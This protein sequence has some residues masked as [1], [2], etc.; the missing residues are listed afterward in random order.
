MP[1]SSSLDILKFRGKK[2]EPSYFFANKMGRIVFLALEEVAGRE[3]MRTILSAAR[4]KDRFDDYPPNDF[5]TDF[6]FG[7]LARIHQAMDKL[8]GPTTGRQLSRRVGRVCF[9]TGAE[10]LRPVLG[11]ADVLFRIL[12]LRTRVRIGFDVLAH[13][14]D[15]FSDQ[16][17]RLEEDQEYFRWV[18]ERCGVCW[19]RETDV[20]CCDLYVGLLEEGLRWFSGG[21]AFFIEESSCIAA[22]QDTCT[23]LVGK[24]PLTDDVPPE[25]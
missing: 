18:N 25:E 13:M 19:G 7:A 15:R 10:E 5:A 2:E 14:S 11:I 8:Y 3:S 16:V 17:V 24:Q 20:P 1:T 9:R 21:T 23:I 22:G 4:M 6:S 12:P